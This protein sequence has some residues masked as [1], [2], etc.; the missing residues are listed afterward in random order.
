MSGLIH[1]C[2]P[3]FTAP[4]NLYFAASFPFL[5]EQTDAGGI[6]EKEAKSGRARTVALPSLVVEEPRRWRLAQAREAL[7]PGVRPERRFGG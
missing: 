2:C 6:R 3:P 5:T 7:K 1:Y 4:I